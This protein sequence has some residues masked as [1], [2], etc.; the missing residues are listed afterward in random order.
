MPPP[1]RL[2][3]DLSTLG[4]PRGRH[5]HFLI[6]NLQDLC[7]VGTPIPTLQT[8]TP[9][10]REVKLCRIIGRTEQTLVSS[11]AVW[12]PHY[13][14]TL[15]HTG[16][17]QTT[18]VYSVTFPEARSLKIKGRIRSGGSREESWPSLFSFWW[19]QDSLA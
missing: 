6:T 3:L 14:D 2:V 15:P 19:L 11:P 9:R 1:F 8:G 4:T 17:L 18:E 10:L 16:G 13:Y 12:D 7:K 5:M